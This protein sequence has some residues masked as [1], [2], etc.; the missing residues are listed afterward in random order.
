MPLPCTAIYKDYVTL[1]S[2]CQRNKF[3]DAFCVVC[4]RSN[5]TLMS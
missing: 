5:K 4:M 2:R 3:F 1:L